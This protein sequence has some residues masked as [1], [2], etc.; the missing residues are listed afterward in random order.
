MPESL[1]LDATCAVSLVVPGPNQP[2]TVALVDGWTR[3]GYGLYAPVLWMY[4][5]TS[6]IAKAVRL[7]GL[8]VAEGERS[9]GQALNL[10]IQLVAAD[11]EQVRAAYAWTVRLNRAAAYDSFY[12]ALAESLGCEL[13]T[14][15]QRL[16]N[17]VGLPW[18]RLAD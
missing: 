2:R 6:A 11:E 3:A 14:A 15:D 10:G 12:L 4:E 5:V 9:L 8:T 17:A 18:V 13:W 1:V 16:V 7:G